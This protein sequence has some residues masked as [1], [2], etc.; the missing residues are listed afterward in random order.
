MRLAGSDAGLHHLDRQRMDTGLEFGV[1]R[2]HHGAMLG[3]AGQAIEPGRGNADT[4]MGLAFGARTGVTP[5]F[6]ALVEHF[7]MAWH[8][9]ERKFFNDGVTN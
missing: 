8:E 6:F 5:M 2:F 9:F 1:E 4:E 3:D 7:K